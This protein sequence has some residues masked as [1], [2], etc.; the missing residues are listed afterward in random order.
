MFID[1][2]LSQP[3]SE[4]LPSLVYWNKYRES[5]LNNIHKMR[6]LGTLDPK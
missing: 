1:Q 6:D 3:S 4:K 2:C 5:Q